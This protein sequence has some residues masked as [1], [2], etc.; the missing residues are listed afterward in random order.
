MSAAIAGSLITQQ[1]TTFSMD[2]YAVDGATVFGYDAND[3]ATVD[4]G[5]NLPAL[6]AGNTM[7]GGSIAG[8]P[9]V[10]PLSASSLSTFTPTLAGSQVFLSPQLPNLF[11]GAFFH[12]ISDIGPAVDGGF[13]LTGGNDTLNSRA[14]LRPLTGPTIP[15]HPQVL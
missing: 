5:A 6:L 3:N 14:L 7:I 13:K 11:H 2:L 15:G 8:I 10:T 4:N 12:P 9:F 1:F